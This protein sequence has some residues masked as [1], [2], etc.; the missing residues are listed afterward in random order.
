MSVVNGI[1]LWKPVYKEQIEKAC[2]IFHNKRNQCHFFYKVHIN[3][4]VIYRR[5]THVL[6]NS[7]IRPTGMKRKLILWLL[8]L[9]VFTI[10]FITDFYESMDEI[11]QW[12]S[13]FHFEIDRIKMKGNSPHRFDLMKTPIEVE[14]FIDFYVNRRNPILKSSFDYEIHHI[15]LKRTN[16]HGIWTEKNPNK[17]EVF[18]DVSP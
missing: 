6:K 8:H 13:H 10:N 5:V 3:I 7:Y 1:G 12:K 15:N 4:F 9:M 16:P 18:L 14:A 11:L 17:V 2:C